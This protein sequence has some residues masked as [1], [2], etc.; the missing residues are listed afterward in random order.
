MH[1]SPVITRILRNSVLLFSKFLAIS[2]RLDPKCSIAILDSFQK[3]PEFFLC[4]VL[5]LFESRKE[6]VI[7]SSSNYQFA[8]FTHLDKH[9]LGRKLCRF[10]SRQPR[11]L[12]NKLPSPRIRCNIETCSLILQVNTCIYLKF[13]M[14][15]TV[16]NASFIIIVEW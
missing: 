8:E 2:A 9:Q 14:C 13:Q 4:S 11:H 12:P 1:F 5:I 16:W 7:I 6:L 10:G 15:Q 3:F